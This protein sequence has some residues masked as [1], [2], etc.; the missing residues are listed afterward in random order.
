MRLTSI[1]AGLMLPITLALSSV[2]ILKEQ[3]R[4]TGG[5]GGH[6]GG[7]GG[8]GG[9]DGRGACLRLCR[10]EKPPCPKNMDPYKLGDCWSCCLRQ[11][12]D[13]EPRSQIQAHYLP[14]VV[15]I[16]LDLDLD[17]FAG[18]NREFL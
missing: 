18:E 16:D 13:S 2:I 3:D 4:T 15:E 12:S 9:D 7:G 5:H 8:D 1:L 6:G 10:P 17:G 11:Q 14:G